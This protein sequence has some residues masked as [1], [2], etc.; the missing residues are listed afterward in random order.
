M[1]GHGGKREG[2]GRKPKADEEKVRNLAV[3]AI[4]KTHGSLEEGFTN[5]L[6]SG[7][8]SLIKFVWE[9]AVGKP[10][11]KMDVDLDNQYSG[12]A[13]VIQAPNGVTIN[14]PDNTE[15]AENLPEDGS[16]DPTV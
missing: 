16:A 8:A 3:S 12:P 14:L 6:K 1:N 11:E 9:H 4:E 7:E 5:L 15:E 10:R 2:S 13:V